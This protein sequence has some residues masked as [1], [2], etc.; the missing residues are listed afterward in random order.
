MA[1]TR[2]PWS[3]PTNSQYDPDSAPNQNVNCGPT[4]VTNCLRF[5]QDKDYRIEDTRNLATSR[6]GIGT[7]SS[8]RKVM[9]DKRGT[10]ASVRYLTAD[11][12][13]KLLTGTRAFELSLKMSEIPLSIRKRP[14]SGGHSV[15]AVAVGIKNGERGIWVHNPDYHRDRGE[16]SLYFYPDQ[17]WIRAFYALGGNWLGQKG[18]WAVVPDKPKVIPSRSIYRHTL[19]VTILCNFRSGPGRQFSIIKTLPIGT[20]LK[21]IEIETDGGSYVVKGVT[22]HDWVSAVINGKPGWIGRGQAKE[23]T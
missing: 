23:I 19:L 3:A 22:R 2:D 21:T 15:E 4:T 20:Q 1:V 8:Q 12:V 14:F 9:F 17:H 16:P 10:A 13:R 11:A 6:N 18:G 7:N 5:M